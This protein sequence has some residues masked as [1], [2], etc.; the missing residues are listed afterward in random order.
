MSPV[1]LFSFIIVYFVILLIVYVVVSFFIIL[2]VY[3]VGFIPIIGTI[4]SF[5]FEILWYYLFLIIL[6]IIFNY[7]YEAEIRQAR[8]EETPDGTA[9]SD[10]MNPEDTS[11]AEAPLSAEPQPETE[12]TQQDEQQSDPQTQQ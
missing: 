9:I 1:L 2:I 12:K 10:S 6:A 5:P 8:P 11:A 7:Y 4:I 3:P